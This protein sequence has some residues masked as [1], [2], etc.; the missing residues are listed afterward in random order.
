MKQDFKNPVFIIG[1][2]LSIGVAL[3]AIVFNDSF[4]SMSNALF[5]FLTVDFAWLYLLVM[6]A[7]VIFAIVIA[8]SR[9]GK[10]KLGPDDSEPEYKTVTWF[11]MLFGCGM[12]VGLV[13]WG[14][15]EP[16]SHY[17]SPMAGI[18]AQ[19]A[20]S[21]QFAMSASFMHWGIHPWANYAIIG[22]ALAYF[23]YRKGKPALIS[24]ALE[25]LIG[26]KNAQG[27]LGKLVDILAVFATI[28][29]VVTSLGLGVLQINSGL[30]YIF[31]I[32]SVLFVQI[33]IILVIS[34]IYIG[35]AVLGIERGISVISNLNLYI[36]IGLMLVCFII[37]P[38]IDVLNNLV[39]GLG[40]YFGTFFQSSL[41]MTA[42]GD[43]SWTLGWRVF[44][45]AWWIAWAPFVGVFIARI[46]KGRT[47]REF[48][49]GVV[50]VPAVASIVWFAV[51]G[52]M[53]LSLGESG[54]LDSE[55]LSAVAAAPETGLF[56]VM[57]QYP[58]GAIISVIVLVLICTFFI[59]SANS[60]TFVLGM[61]SSK[62]SLNPSNAKK[63][64]WGVV[65][66]ALAIGLLIAGGLK[67]LQTISIAAAFPFI[68]IMLA[69]MVSLVK[70][71]SHDA[72]TPNVG[73]PEFEPNPDLPPSA[74][75][76]VQKTQ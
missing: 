38:K 33:V 42:Y 20:E 48:V 26:T 29:G 60:G 70:G 1:L 37:G 47:V 36:A 5:E 55:T 35:S 65:Q 46:S 19:S 63:V 16:I 34:V 28:A 9:F 50:L 51:F 14:I 6:L 15:A 39:G 68:F 74:E 21:A 76:V 25:P 45:W 54:I 7:F 17:M 64:L 24:S 52:S 23:Q 59:T 66:S 43:N 44:Y 13:F 58:L 4:T 56:I 30:N 8:C 72:D 69:A 62:G 67:P 31:G 22:L 75:P 3:W 41:G 73:D 2:V 71:M 10:I 32:P 18:E 57:N 40:D 61:L 49:G 27:G 11:A 12:G 53:G